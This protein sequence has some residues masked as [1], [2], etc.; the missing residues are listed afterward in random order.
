MPPAGHSGFW[1]EQAIPTACV[2]AKPSRQ[3]LPGQGRSDVG[4]STLT[5]QALSAPRCVDEGRR[6]GRFGSAQPEL[7]LLSADLPTLDPDAISSDVMD[8]PGRAD[9][10]RTRLASEESSIAE[11]SRHKD[12]GAALRTAGPRN[13]PACRTG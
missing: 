5:R 3:G 2:Q 9:S 13:V 8:C 6:D 11:L 10:C 1:D 4:C 7:P 12:Q